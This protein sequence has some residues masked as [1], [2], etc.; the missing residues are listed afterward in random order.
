MSDMFVHNDD[1]G[2]KVI[3]LDP[4]EVITV[5]LSGGNGEVFVIDNDEKSVVNEDGF[6]ITSAAYGWT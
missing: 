1:F 5:E 3:I 2:R 6:N 4:G